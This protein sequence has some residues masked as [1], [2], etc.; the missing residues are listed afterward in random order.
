MIGKDWREELEGSYV[1]ISIIRDIAK[2]LGD[3]DIIE[4]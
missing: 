4:L 1:E 3:R 2:W